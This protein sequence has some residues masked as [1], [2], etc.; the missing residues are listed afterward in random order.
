MSPKQWL[1]LLCFYVSY[2]IFGASIFYHIEHGLEAERRAYQ[3]D[4]RIEVNELLVRY[5][6]PDDE[7][8]QNQVL[9]VV[10]DYCGRPVTNYT[11]DEFPD[12]Y[13]WTIYHSFWFA[14]TLC[15]TVGYG[16]ISP[17][18]SLGQIIVIFYALVG[19]PVNGF[20]LAYLG[21]LFGKTFIGIYNRYKDYKYATT[22]NYVPRQFGMIGRI[23]LFLVPG[24]AFFIFLPACLFTYFEQWPYITSVYYSFVTLTTI[25]F[26]DYVPTFQNGQSRE[27]GVYFVFYQIF[28]IFWNLLGLGY[29]IMIIGFIAK[30]LQSK[31]IARL[32]HQL[33]ENLKATQSRIWSGVTKDVSFLRRILNEV[34]L[35][36]VK[37][38]YTDSA[39]RAAFNSL[40]RSSSCPDL[41]LYREDSPRVSRKRAYSENYAQPL[42]SSTISSLTLC[43]V[44]SEGD[45]S[46]IDKKKTFE[47]A[48]AT[49]KTGDLL[50]RVVNALGSIR[51]SDEDG[52]SVLEL[53][54]DGGMQGFTD[55][56]IL[57][58][59]RTWSGWSLSQSDGSYTNPPIRKRAASDF[60]V[61]QIDSFN[62]SYESTWNGNNDQQM[63]EYMKRSKK[64]FSIPE[65]FTTKSDSNNRSVTLNIPDTLQV[66][67]EARNRSFIS[68]IN[69]FKARVMGQNGKRHS[70]AVGATQDPNPQIY[71]ERTSRG[72]E[73][74]ISLPRQY[75]AATARGRNSVFSI[76]EQPQNADNSELLEKTTIAD[77][78]RALEVIHTKANITTESSLLGYGEVPKR[79]VG[80]VTP[81]SPPNLSHLQ[82]PNNNRRGSL[83]PVPGYTTVFATQNTSRR[84]SL[85]LSPESVSTDRR[86]SMASLR[87]VNPPPYS[88][89]PKPM[90]RRFSVRPTNLS[91]PPGQAP[92]P[93][94]SV[95]ASSML[96]RK[97]SLRPSPLARHTPSQGSGRYAKQGAQQTQPQTVTT[98]SAN[99]LQLPGA[100][101][102]NIMWRPAQLHASRA[103]HSSLTELNE[104]SER[105]RADSK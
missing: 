12:D 51:P 97:L 82:V 81:P 94:P 58:S 32:E 3:L 9:G 76:L 39:E 71:L 20:L 36:K 73:S 24:I 88:A 43:R 14:L 79:K 84:K 68:K 7:D 64:K 67:T 38:V 78:I 42:D 69:P 54:I 100:A 33:S 66:P 52:Q 2:L 21:D 93:T 89:T 34:N 50:S 91:I 56:Q 23:M 28:I 74:R 27:F 46:R 45:L 62:D 63:K 48:D 37:P 25:G 105:K 6:S 102:R 13:Q 5:V 87:P 30:G 18:D 49:H 90:T 35:M 103:E 59:E 75:L 31:R 83:R 17:H 65:I 8:N 85:F 70:V 61:P 86:S 60:R 44:Q 29:F 77:L 80:T 92:S 10:S 26:G 95:Q 104:K 41:T 72:R 40:H 22:K 53:G 11:L 1:A 47:G 55:S 4:E 96:Q 99:R 19:L 98:P 15:S 16:N 101:T 57:A